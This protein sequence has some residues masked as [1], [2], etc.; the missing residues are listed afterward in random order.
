MN[1]SFSVVIGINPKGKFIQ[2]KFMFKFEFLAD[3][4]VPSRKPKKKNQ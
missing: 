4:I 3:R 2:R 1:F